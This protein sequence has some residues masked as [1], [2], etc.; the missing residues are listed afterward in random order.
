M[1]AIRY[2]ADPYQAGLRVWR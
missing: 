2:F 1:T